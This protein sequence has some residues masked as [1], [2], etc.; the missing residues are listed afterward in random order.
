MR[1]KITAATLF[2]R[3]ATAIATT[4]R[5]GDA[6]AKQ[7]LY[8]IMKGQLQQWR[9]NMHGYFTLDTAIMITRWIVFCVTVIKED[10]QM[11]KDLYAIV[12][13]YEQLFTSRIEAL[14]DAD[15]SALCLQKEILT[16]IRSKLS[17]VI[18]ENSIRDSYVHF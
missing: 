7:K 13:A 4:Q 5:C 2:E 15:Q 12:Q 11:S 9:E 16:R 8:T 18:L 6:L 10:A 17:P 1:Q 3:C 14:T